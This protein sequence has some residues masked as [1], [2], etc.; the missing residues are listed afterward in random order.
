MVRTLSLCLA[1]LLLTACGEQSNERT[2]PETRVASE[3][4]PAIP[5]ATSEMRFGSKPIADQHTHEEAQNP[6]RWTDPEGW[7]VLPSSPMRDANFEAGDPRVE[8]YVTR[9]PGDA[10][11]LI[12]NVNRWRKQMG[13]AP[14]DEAAVRALDTRPILGAPATVVELEGT[15]TGM[16]SEPQ[17]GTKLIGAML[18]FPGMGTLFVKMV[19]PIEVVDRERARYEAFC[20]SLHLD[21]GSGP[22][23]GADHSEPG[24]GHGGGFEW[25]APTM[26]QREGP[27][28]MRLVSFT[29][30]SGTECYISVLGGAAGGL[31]ANLNRWRQQLG[32]AELGS[33][34]IAALPKIEVLGQDSIL[35]EGYGDF[36]GMNDSTEKAGMLGIVCDLGT[37]VLFV[38]M[39]GPEGAVR[40]GREGFIAFCASIRRSL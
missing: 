7:T 29:L 12:A 33:A 1:S 23:P 40:A 20:D 28:S 15:F 8:C 2:I 17:A 38:K 10:G 4:M 37:E 9:L 3:P 5:N 36:T 18:S 26:W 6:L 19:G 21:T 32:L 25:S 34:E 30:G 16:G 27:R 14:L 22:A 24:H 39:V 31:E 11:G 35:F 13:L